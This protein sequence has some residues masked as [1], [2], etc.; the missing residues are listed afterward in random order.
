MEIVDA[1]ARFEWWEAHQEG[2][3]YDRIPHLGELALWLLK[4][5]KD[6]LDEAHHLLT[7]LFGEPTWWTRWLSFARTD[8]LA[9]CMEKGPEKPR[10]A[11]ELD[12]TLPMYIDEVHNKWLDTEPSQR[13]RH[14]LGPLIASWQGQPTPATANS[15]SDPILP[16]K[17]AMVEPASGKTSTLFSPAAHFHEHTNRQLV[18]PGFGVEQV[19]GP[20][21]PLQL[22]DLGGG[23]SLE[24]GRGAPLALRLFIEAILSVPLDDRDRPVAMSVTLRELLSW[25]Y[26]GQRQPR[27][28]EYW[29]RLNAAVEALDRPE[30]RIPWYD[31]QT[32]RGGS[33]RVVTATDIP[34]GPGAL[35]D[36]VTMTVHLPPGSDLGP[37]IDRV[38]L[39]RW[40]V[41][42]GPAY[43]AMIGLAYRWFRPGVTR[44]PVVKDKRYWMQTQSP[45]R[46][47][48]PITNEELVSLFYPTATRQQRR[49]LLSDAKKVLNAMIKEGDVRQIK[50]RLLPPAPIKL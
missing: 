13:L 8:L 26:P 42:R 34:R 33:R 20:A 31:P 22:Y 25:L 12:Y 50:G 11:V 44:V 47:G 24:R 2:C 17:L 36:L 37:V 21:L 15:R 39:R 3:P 30:A 16:I 45:E 40:G 18:L 4:C 9:C 1:V 23:S 43:R 48:A 10:M 7:L 38:R 41:R 27:P 35:D 14:P 5:P 29:P 46:Y 32:K 49:N 6:A 28:N 19:R